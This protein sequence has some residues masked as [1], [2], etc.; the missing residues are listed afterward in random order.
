MFAFLE[1]WELVAVIG[2]VV[3]LFGGTQLP[4]LARSIGQAQKEFKKGL[5]EGAKDDKTDTWSSCC[6]RRG[7]SA[8]I[9][10]WPSPNSA[11]LMRPRATSP[12]TS[13]TRATRATVG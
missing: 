9:A 6:L 10:A 4:K 12:A 8:A 2:I 13:T 7:T 3:L 5:D 11:W 1:G